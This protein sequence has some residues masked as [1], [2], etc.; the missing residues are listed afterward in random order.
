MSNNPFTN[1]GAST[2]GTYL[3]SL[4][5]VP[6]PKMPPRST[7]RPSR[8][9]KDLDDHIYQN[10]ASIK[11]DDSII[12]ARIEQDFPGALRYRGNLSLSLYYQQLQACRCSLRTAIDMGYCEVSR[13]LYYK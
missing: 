12:S 8:D 11:V 10:P 7:Y 9:S 4:V 2:S 5:P 3:S 13:Y 6:T 1:D